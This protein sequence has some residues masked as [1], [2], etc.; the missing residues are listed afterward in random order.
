MSYITVIRREAEEIARQPGWLMLYGRRKVGKTFLLKNMVKWDL[1]ISVRRDLSI[2]VEPEREVSLNSLA[3][4][5]VNHL[6]NGE[7]VIVDEFQRL[8]LSVLEDFCRAH[9]KGKLILAGSSLGV[10]RKYI[11][12]SSPLLGFFIPYKLSLINPLDIL[13]ELAKHRK[14][15]E[16][17]ELAALLREPWLIPLADGKTPLQ[18]LYEASCKYWQLVKALIGEIFTEEE[19]TLTQTYEA[20][21]S[22]VGSGVWE[23]KNLASILYSRGITSEPGA[24]AITPYLKNLQEMDLLEAKQIHRSRKK[25]YQLKSPIMEAY[26]Y[27]DSRYDVSERP[28]AQAEVEPTLKRLLTQQIQSFTA[29]FFQE[30]LQGRWEYLLQPEVDFIITIRGKPA[31]IGEV[32][33]GNYTKKDLIH[34]KEK[35][36]ALPGRKL[37]ITK[38]RE[39]EVEGVDVLEAEDLISLA[40]QK[41]PSTPEP[42]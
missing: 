6:Q 18:L 26:Y 8:P 36:E 20:I 28:I 25:Y 9:P 31:A 17:V 4:L 23:A 33:W 12:P 2:R 21:L 29:L 15:E 39:H 35:V 19:R 10:V 3:D 13:A 37:F 32:K 42:L 16:A 7:T 22:L 40:K 41:T 27:L 38:K 24:N 11:S 1:Y 30:L 34:F 5:V 14:A